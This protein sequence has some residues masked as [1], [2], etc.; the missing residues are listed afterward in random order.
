MVRRTMMQGL[1]NCCQ[2]LDN[3]IDRQ[4]A[5]GIFSKARALAHTSKDFSV[6][7]LKLHLQPY[8]LH[9]FNEYQLDRFFKFLMSCNLLALL[10]GKG[11][12]E[13]RIVNGDYFF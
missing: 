8:A 7:R 2:I 13:M 9:H 11:P 6:E 12:S 3:N 4:T 10:Q 1:M 5:S